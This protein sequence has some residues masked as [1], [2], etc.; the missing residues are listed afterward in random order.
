MDRPSVCKNCE[1]YIGEDS[2]KRK[3]NNYLE[4][5]EHGQPLKSDGSVCKT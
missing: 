4:L 3:F 5:A 1:N 2:S